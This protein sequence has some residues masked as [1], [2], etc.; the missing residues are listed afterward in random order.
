MEARHRTWILGGA[1]AFALMALT[2]AGCRSETKP[3]VPDSASASAAATLK[4]ETWDSVFLAGEHVGY[5]HTLVSREPGPSGDVLRIEQ[6]ESLT[7]RRDS[8]RMETQSAFTSQET[9]DGQFLEFR[10]VLSQGDV[11]MET[12]GRVVDNELQL[13]VSTMGRKTKASLAWKPEFGG[14]YCVANSLLTKPLVP[15][16]SRSLCFFDIATN[17]PA[18]RVMTAVDFEDTQLLTETRRLLRVDARTTLGG[19]TINS[20][21]WTDEGGDIYKEQIPEMHDFLVVRSTKAE[22]TKEV[23]RLKIDLNTLSAVPVSQ[24]IPSPYKTRRIVYRVHLKSADPANVFANGLTQQV[25]AEDEHTA[26]I[27]VYS[28]RPVGGAGNPQAPSEVVTDGDREPNNLIQ[29]DDPTVVKLAQEAAGDFRADA[30]TNGRGPTTPAGD[31][32]VLSGPPSDPVQV[33]LALEKFVSRRMTSQGI[34]SAFATAAEV[35]QT[36]EG[37]CTEHAVLLAAMARARGIPS[38]VAIGLVYIRQQFLYH[39]WT[40]VF[41]NGRWI[42]LDG[43]LGQGGIGAA[44]LKITSSNLQGASPNAAFLPVTKVMGQLK[45]EVLEVE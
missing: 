15:G 10:S 27:T 9:P 43:T 13:E 26:R 31:S 25:V 8:S 41:L 35:A 19:F 14:P 34:S 4:R 12:T 29:S 45:I 21:L 2:L 18:T 24:P 7:I 23:G 36:L 6:E 44:Y 1:Q 20:T 11:P 30:R 17:Q 37:D 3:P 5:V 40:E 33:A 22:A 32:P 42:P 39:M 38:R 16:E 28:V